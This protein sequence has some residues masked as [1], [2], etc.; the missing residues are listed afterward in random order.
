MRLRIVDLPQ[1]EGP[2]IEVKDWSEASKLMLSS[3]RKRLPFWSSKSFVTSFSIMV[4][5]N[6][7]LLRPQHQRRSGAPAGHSLFDRLEQQVLD[8]EHHQKK[9]QRPREDL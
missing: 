1:P 2:R 9:K 4:L 6:R 8:G 5:T 7:C 3:T